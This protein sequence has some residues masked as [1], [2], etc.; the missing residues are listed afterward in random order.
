MGD[1]SS[2]RRVSVRASLAKANLYILTS[3]AL[4]G[5]LLG[6]MAVSI[7]LTVFVSPY[8]AL[9]IILLAFLFKYVMYRINK[10]IYSFKVLQNKA[11]P[12]DDRQY[13]FKI[14][15]TRDRML[16]RMIEEGVC[17]WSTDRNCNISNCTKKPCHCQA[18]IPDLVELGYINKNEEPVILRDADGFT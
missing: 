9:A 15:E 14:E 4:M 7:I 5:V 1:F 8:F 2:L 12:A 10:V 13:V 11:Y 16:A 17:P 3:I 18:H 6:L